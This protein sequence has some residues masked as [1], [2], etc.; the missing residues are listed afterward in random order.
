MNGD[1]IELYL[2]LRGGSLA[3]APVAT[4]LQGERFEGQ[5]FTVEPVSGENRIR[6]T[7]AGAGTQWSSAESI[8]LSL[9][10]TTPSTPG[11]ALVVMKL[12][13]LDGRFGAAEWNVFPI[14]VLTADQTPAAGP[15]GPEGPQG[16]AG[17][18]GEV[19]P[20]GPVGGRGPMGDSGP[21]GPQGEPGSAG[22]TGANGA[23]GAQGPAGPAGETG[24]TGPA[25]PQGET[26]AAGA[27]GATG[28][29]GPQG[30]VGPA[31]AAGAQGA[32][33]EVGP[34][35]PAGAQGAQGE[36]GP[37]GAQGPAGPQGAAGATGAAG[38][39][40]VSGWTRTSSS[41]ATDPGAS[42]VTNHSVSCGAKKVVG[43]GCRITVDL[44]GGIIVGS[45]PGSDNTWDCVFVN[46][47]G[48][49]TLEAHAICADIAIPD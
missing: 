34:A 19:G 2:D 47:T 23:T 22:A 1:T 42:A 10:I 7:Y 35:G 38:A 45:Y 30:D 26:G 17:P 12:P 44:E 13:T 9:K 5:N 48:G 21:R 11:V 41:T 3:E 29:A 37:A 24:A 32:Q 6:I 31:G 39:N 16:P 46:W 15:Q 40:G 25:G 8:Q 36:V 49:A 4:L 14:N 27:T 43:G 28:A 20:L 18:Q 33:G